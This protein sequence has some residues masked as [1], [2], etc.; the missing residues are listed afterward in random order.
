[1]MEHPLLDFL[2]PLF[3]TV[4]CGFAFQQLRSH[5]RDRRIRRITAR[6]IEW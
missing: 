1:M 6:L 3:F 5:F 2:V 4:S